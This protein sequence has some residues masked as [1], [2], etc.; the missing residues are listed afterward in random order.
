MGI[1]AQDGFTIIETVLFL[2]ISAGL[3]IF[4]M[5]AAGTSLN[6]QRYRDAVESFKS[7]VQQQYS[8]L[9]NVQNGRTNTWT[10]NTTNAV[11]T[12]GGSSPEF[13]GQSDCFLIGKYMR[14]ERSDVTIY[15]VLASQRA[16]TATDD[17]TSMRSNY[18]MS[19][20]T[21]ETVE[22]KLEWG[23]EIAWPR[24]GS[25][26]VKSPAT[27]RS[28][29]ILFVRSPD[30]GQIYTFTSDTVP[31]KNAVGQ[32]TFTNILVSGTATPGRGQSE[33][34]ICLYS[35]GLFKGGDS[36][37]RLTAFATGISNVETRSNAYNSS[38]GGS[39]TQ[40]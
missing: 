11:P 7:L 29:G 6:N 36:E 12:Q 38:L 15:P 14:I 32:S 33:R 39:P 17:V 30:S 37:L 4:M 1:R 21:G 13:R 23:T 27:P 25:V 24:S 19:V 2:A 26:D 20:A 22:K 35:G 31:A 9:A 5:A 10:C 16:T 40:C 8:D 3:V 28:I 34:S 18:A